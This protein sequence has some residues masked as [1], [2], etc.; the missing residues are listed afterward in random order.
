V[1]DMWPDVHIGISD[2][3]FLVRYKDVFQN[4]KYFGLKFIEGPSGN[5][6]EA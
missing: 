4:L 6:D 1:S 5:L 3:A 2:G